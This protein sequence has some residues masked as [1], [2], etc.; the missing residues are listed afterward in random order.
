M[1]AFLLKYLSVLFFHTIFHQ[2][3][4]LMKIKYISF[5]RLA[6]LLF[7]CLAGCDS[8][9][10]DDL[11]GCPQGVNFEFYRQTPCEQSP[12]YPTEIRQLRI[13]AFDERERLV[14]VFSEKDI[15]L[16]PEYRYS[17]PF[18]RK[19]KFTFVAWGGSDLSTYV[20]SAFKKGSTSKQEME[21]AL[22]L[23]G[24]RVSSA[25]GPL[26]IGFSGIS[27]VGKENSGTFYER[28]AFNMQELTYR[29]HFTIKSTPNPFPTGENFI[30][31]IE[32]DNG[33]YD[34]S[35][36]IAPCERFEYTAD[37]VCDAN[38]VLKVDFILMK[39]EE[40]RNAIVSVINKTTGKAIYTANLVDDIILY[41][42][43]F[44]VPPYSLECDHDFPI[45]LIFNN[46]GETWNLIQAAVL[47]WNVVSRP[48][49]LD[50]Y[51]R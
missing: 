41:K 36:K 43:D 38:G 11:S 47:D 16:S 49:E 13:F 25:S 7:C 27:M 19:G 22:R 30:I 21:V 15:I 14:D 35:G 10:Y 40:G 29:I 45:T 46:E 51:G 34:F 17:V 1:Y 23:E 50:Y 6:I 20:F 4:Y 3:S 37:A 33:V 8:V 39:L 28:V 5:L 42:E 2:L 48:V 44:G 12:Y 24:K 18:N 31:K 9:V 26:Y 32:D